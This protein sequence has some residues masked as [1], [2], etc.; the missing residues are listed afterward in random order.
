[1]VIHGLLVEPHEMCW[2]GSPRVGGHMEILGDREPVG[3]L[4]SEPRISNTLSL[5]I[6]MKAI[7]AFAI[8]ALAAT[9]W[10]V[11]PPAPGTAV[12]CSKYLSKSSRIACPRHFKPICGSDQKTY[13]NECMFCMQNQE[14]GLFLRKLHDDRCIE[15]SSNYSE[16]CT[17][18][19]MPHCGSDGVVYGNKCLFCNGVVKSRGA[20]FLAKYGEC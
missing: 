9:A 18:E 15:C 12:D 6:T 11:S 1:M 19:Y 7:S 4:C 16:M 17:M 20:L 2:S 8:L 14:K 5:I 13:S 10:A 3:T